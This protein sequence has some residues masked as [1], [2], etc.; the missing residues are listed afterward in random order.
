MFRKDYSAESSL[1]WSGSFGT[2]ETFRI[3]QNFRFVY[4]PIKLKHSCTQ[5]ITEFSV[6][7]LSGFRELFKPE[8]IAAPKHENL[9][10]KLSFL[11]TFSRAA[12]SL[13]SEYGLTEEQVAG[14]F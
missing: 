12:P 3:F 10:I 4:D 11:F 8:F 7:N 1:Y 14:E 13:Q 5:Q 2:E 9:L 6:R